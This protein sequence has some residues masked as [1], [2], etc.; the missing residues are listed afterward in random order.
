MEDDRQVQPVQE[1]VRDIN[2]KEIFRNPKLCSQ[3]LR[4]NVN[5][6][7]LKQIKPE[8]IED[9]T[10]RY[11]AYLG[12]EFESDTV[13]KIRLKDEYG[14][15]EKTPLYLVSLIEHKSDVDHDIMMQLLRYMVCIWHEYAKEKEREKKGISHQKGFQ[16]PP[17]LP[18]VY[19]EGT[20]NWT[21]SRHLSDRIQASDVFGRYVPDFHYELVRI[22]SYSNEELLDRGDEMSLLMLLNKLQNPEDFHKFRLSP[23]EKLADIL[24]N[25]DPHI[26]KLMQ[27]VMYSLM[28]KMNIPVEEANEHVKAMGGN[29]MGY[30]FENMEKMD[31]Q[32]ERRNTAEAR[33]RADEAEQRADEAEQRAAKA[34]KQLQEIQKEMHNSKD[35][36]RQLRELEEKNAAIRKESEHKSYIAACKE[37]HCTK[38]EAVERF[39]EKFK[40]DFGDSI[41]RSREIAKEKVELYWKEA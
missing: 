8:D 1:H 6:P 32:A 33:K 9:V 34:E 35:A 16:Y 22:H 5:I 4:D 29:Q 12:V 39:A 2:S 11:Q 37:F 31:I 3:F 10:E 7:Q 25:A 40:A 14:K 21:A 36:E 18:I 23:P 19:Y 30:L 26:I 17:V 13:K 20:G 28:M 15:Q 38:E 41:Q 24:K 27:D